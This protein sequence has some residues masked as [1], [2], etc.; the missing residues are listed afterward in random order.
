MV[1]KAQKLL[2]PLAQHCEMTEPF[3]HGERREQV[4]VPWR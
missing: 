1:E 4:L 3:K 2:M